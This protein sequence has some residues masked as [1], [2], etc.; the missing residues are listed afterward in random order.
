MGEHAIMPHDQ[1]SSATAVGAS[2]LPCASSSNSMMLSISVPI[3]ML[4]TRSRMISMTTG[5]LILRHPLLRLL[6]RRVDLLLLVD[7]D[8]LA[9]QTLDNLEV[10]DAV[11]ADL[12]RVDVLERELTRS[13]PCRSRAAPGGSGPRY[14]LLTTMWRYGSLNCAPTASSSI[15]NWKS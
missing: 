12:R 13:S 6:D 2:S 14:E 3:A 8:R 5:T 4:V 7:A 10:I 15:M 9:A 11:A 1:S